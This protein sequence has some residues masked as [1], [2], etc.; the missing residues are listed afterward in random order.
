[1][2]MF[3]TLDLGSFEFIFHI[4]LSFNNEWTIKAADLFFIVRTCPQLKNL[5][6]CLLLIYGHTQ[7]EKYYQNKKIII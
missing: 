7:W 2:K 4:F 5:Y 6:D 3:T 1:M